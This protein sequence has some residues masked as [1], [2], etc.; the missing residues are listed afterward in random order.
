MKIFTKVGDLIIKIFNLI[1]MIILAIP[2]I[3]NRLRGI[4]T[5]DIKDKVDTDSIKENISKIKNDTRIKEGISKI[6]T[7]ETPQTSKIIEKDDAGGTKVPKSPISSGEFT[8]EEKERTVFILQLLSGG[9]LVVSMLYLFNFLMFFLYAVFSIILVGSTIYLLFNKVKLMY[10][11]DFNA[12]RDFFLMYT[13]VGIILVLVGSNPAFVMSFSFEFLPSL[14]ILIFALI[15]VVAVFLIFRI[16]YHRNFTYGTVIETGK[17][18]AYV[19]VEYDICSNVKPDIYVV[20][21]SFGAK[22]GDTVKVQIEESIMS[23]GGNKPSMIT[24]TLK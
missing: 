7:K 6:S 21:N 18:T 16:R 13:A 14:S 2:K 17:K 15:A 9:F 24:E 1:G 4:S 8:S 11:A 12:Y 19:K 23:M 3:P 22:D 5:A 10:T 20:D